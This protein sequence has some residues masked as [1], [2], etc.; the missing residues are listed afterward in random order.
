MKLENEKALIRTI[1]EGNT[2]SFEVLFYSYYPRLKGFICDLLQSPEEA[3]DIS[4]DIFTTLWQNRT[5]L[6]KIDNISAYLFRIAKNAV[7]RHI[8]RNMLFKNYQQK[9]TESTP[10]VIE[11][12][13]IYKYIDAKELELLITIAVERMPPQRQ[14]IYKM[15]REQGMSNDEIAASSVCGYEWGGT[16][17][18]DYDTTGWVIEGLA[19]VNKE[20]YATTINKAIDIENCSHY[21]NNVFSIHL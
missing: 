16:Y 8:E 11:D 1:A 12:N 19:V 17:Y 2:K 5:S 7:Y 20:K 3:E 15:S 13:E 14:R 10:N 21:M 4:Q 9:Q 6:D 18:A